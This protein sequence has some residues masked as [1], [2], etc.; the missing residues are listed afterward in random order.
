MNNK[1]ICNLQIACQ[2]LHGLPSAK[3]IKL[4]VRNIFITHKKK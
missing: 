1:I 4:W 3:K 2:N